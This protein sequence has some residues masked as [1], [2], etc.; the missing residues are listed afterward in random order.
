MTRQLKRINKGILTFISFIIV[1]AIVGVVRLGYFLGSEANSKG[2]NNNP[3][4]TQSG[5]S[6]IPPVRADLPSSCATTSTD[7]NC[8]TDSTDCSC[9]TGTTGGITTSA[10]DESEGVGGGGGGGSSDGGSG[11][12]GGY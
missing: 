8:P 12:G 4:E 10:V 7:G 11:C 2:Q 9:T 5:N 6:F 3:N 1:S